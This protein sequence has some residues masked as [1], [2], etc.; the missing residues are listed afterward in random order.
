[1]ILLQVLGALL[2]IRVAILSVF[3]ESNVY[4]LQIP[5]NGNCKMSGIQIGMLQFDWYSLAKF[6]PYFC[7]LVA[8]EAFRLKFSINMDFYL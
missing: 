2:H 7:L 6:E 1:V 3:N 4:L 5:Y 8:V